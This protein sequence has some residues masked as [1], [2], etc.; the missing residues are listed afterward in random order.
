[1]RGWRVGGIRCQGKPGWVPR[2]PVFLPPAAGQTADGAAESS[3]LFIRF[4]SPLLLVEFAPALSAED[5]ENSQNEEDPGDDEA[6]DPQGLVVV[7]E[8]VMFL[9]SFCS[10]HGKET[11]TENQDAVKRC[12]CPGEH[13]ELGNTCPHFP[14][15]LEPEPKGLSQRGT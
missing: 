2:C 3:L 6:S 15:P 14:P 12:H 5:D 10:G 13:Q 7:C 4:P 9:W 8:W 1:M 11:N